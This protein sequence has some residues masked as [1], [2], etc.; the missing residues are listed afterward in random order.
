MIPLAAI[1][2]WLRRMAA[3]APSA[4]HFDPLFRWAAIGAGIA[5]ALLALRLAEPSAPPGTSSVPAASVPENPGPSYG[6]AAGASLTPSA[7]TAAPKIAPGRSLDAVTI[8]PGP[9]RD[10]FGTI[11]SPTHR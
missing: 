4:W 10:P 7:S 8:T 6:A 11:P 3:A 5:L 9:E 2:A 1:R